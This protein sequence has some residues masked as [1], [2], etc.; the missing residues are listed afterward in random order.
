[1]RRHTHQLD[2]DPELAGIP[3]TVDWP[4]HVIWAGT[5]TGAPILMARV[6]WTVFAAL[7]PSPGLWDVALPFVK[8]AKRRRVA[9]EAR[10][11]L[12]IHGGIIAT[13][14]VWYPPLL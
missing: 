5:I 2:G 10:L 9:W 6:M 14:I 4:K 12:F 11:L 7:I 13:G 8:P 3:F 1:M